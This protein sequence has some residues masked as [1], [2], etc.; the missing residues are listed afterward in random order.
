MMHQ[1]ITHYRLLMRNAK[2]Q[3]IGWGLI[4]FIAVLALCAAGMVVLK[5]LPPRD[6]ARVLQRL[7]APVRVAVNNWIFPHP[8]SVPAPSAP[9]KNISALLTPQ[10]THPPTITPTFTPS[11]A[12]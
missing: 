6:Q 8:E 9:V 12:P 4:G 1:A 10:A 5:V 2:Q 7:P 3:L 11:P